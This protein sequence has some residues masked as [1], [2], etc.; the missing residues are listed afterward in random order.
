[1]WNV[2]DHEDDVKDSH[3]AGHNAGQHETDGDGDDNLPHSLEE[4]EDELSSPSTIEL[5]LEQ[6]QAL[7]DHE[8]KI[9]LPDGWKCKR[10]LLPS[11]DPSDSSAGTPV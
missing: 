1:M 7:P 10:Y 11:A 6:V 4:D 9:P 8:V 3:Q 2:D 5:S